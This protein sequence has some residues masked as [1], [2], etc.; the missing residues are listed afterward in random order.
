LRN[1]YKKNL[2][3]WLESSPRRNEEMEI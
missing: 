1:I 2:F 3:P